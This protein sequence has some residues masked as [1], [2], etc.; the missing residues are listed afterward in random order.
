MGHTA[1]LEAS[2]LTLPHSLPYPFDLSAAITAKT[3]LYIK[4]GEELVGAT[5]NGQVN[6]YHPQRET[7]I[8]LLQNGEEKY[9]VTIPAEAS[10][11]G[12]VTQAFSIPEVAEGT[13]DLVVSKAGHLA[14]TI[15][16]VVMGAE[17]LDLTANSN[18]AIS[19]IT[20]LAGDLNGDGSINTKDRTALNRNLNLAGSDIIEALAD[21][22]GDGLVNS[23]DRTILKKNLN[24]SAEN[25]CI[26]NY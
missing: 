7:V 1:Y 16:G 13:Y 26:I 6:S 12:Q 19:T 18:A 3:T 22:N 15:R 2:V 5:L 9:S 24:K 17:N 4:L 14:F 21:I 11:S 23:K 10:G 25:D 20:L 8:R